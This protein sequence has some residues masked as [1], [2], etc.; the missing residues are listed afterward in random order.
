LESLASARLGGIRAEVIVVDNGSHDTTKEVALLFRERIPVRYYHETRIGIYGKS[1]ALNRALDAGRLGKIIA[2]LDDDMSVQA[3]WFEGV[4]AI[5]RRWPDKDLFTGKTYIIW[6]CVDV[7]DW[8][9]AGRLHSWI[10][11]AV[12]VGD[13]DSVLSEGRWHSGNH[14]WFRSRVLD[15]GRRFKDMWLTEPDF[16]LDL[17]ELGHG[18]VAGPDA[19]AGHRVQPALLQKEV[20]LDR[21][22]KLGLNGAWLR[23]QPYRKTVKQARLLHAHPWA[24]RVF[25]LLN[26]L[27]WR[28]LYL[29]S[30]V[31]GSDA[32][33]F[34]SR[35]IALERMTTY[36]ELF[37]AANRLED[38]SLWTRNRSR[39]EHHRTNGDSQLRFK[40]NQRI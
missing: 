32:T 11:S 20:A 17:A 22:R 13:S 3:E 28:F 14:F 23:L 27:R 15:R 4:M 35:L 18:G 39:T 7:P 38:Y 34:E 26:H 19:I 36:L 8:A 21:A 12:Y 40:G 1:H 33:R 10:F 24:A 29:L 6:P 5:S 16:Q 2:V 30:Y 9:K 31:Y 37:R 25:C